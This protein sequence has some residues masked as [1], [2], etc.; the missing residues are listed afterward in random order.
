[1]DDARS[2]RL[3]EFLTNLHFSNAD[4]IQ[5]K[6]S[7]AKYLNLKESKRGKSVCDINY[8]SDIKSTVKGNLDR[9]FRQPTARSAVL[10]LHVDE[11]YD[12]IRLIRFVARGNNDF[13][14][15]TIFLTGKYGEG[16]NGFGYRYEHPEDEGNEHNFFHVQPIV[17]TAADEVIPGAPEWLS[18]RFPSFYMRAEDSYELGIY[19]ISSMCSWRDLKR[20]QSMAYEDCW[21]LKH[22]ISKGQEAL[23][24]EGQA[25]R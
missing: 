11:K 10:I 21:L 5:S 2:Q 12:W 3:A 19:A 15:E 20:Y 16:Y 14:A 13:N 25:G 8:S 23:Q 22:L 1:M 24:R 4:K 7:L 17:V 9:F 18:H 6:R